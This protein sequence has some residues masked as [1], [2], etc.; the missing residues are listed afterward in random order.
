M[1]HPSYFTY[2]YGGREAVYK[3]GLHA[4]HTFKETPENT[5]QEISFSISSEMFHLTLCPSV[6]LKTQLCCTMEN[7]ISLPLH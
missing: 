6:K 3:K 1:I 2:F 4:S 7:E 5:P